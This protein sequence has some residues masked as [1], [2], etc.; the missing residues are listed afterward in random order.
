MR[1]LGIRQ[2]D[3]VAVL[4]NRDEKVVL[5]QLAVLKIG[6]VF[7]PIDSRYP[8]DRIKYILSESGAKSYLSE[9][10]DAIVL[11]DCLFEK[12]A[13]TVNSQGVMAIAPMAPFQN[14]PSD[15]F[16]LYLDRIRDPG[17]LGTIFRSAAACGIKD[18]ILDDCVDIYNPKTIRSSMGMY[19]RCN[20]IPATENVSDGY[21]LVCADADGKD[22]RQATADLRGRPICLVIG[23]EADGV[24]KELLSRADLT[25]SLP[26]C[27]NVESLNAAVS[28]S[29]AMYWFK[30]F[31]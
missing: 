21:M 14:I 4:L 13:D 5:A 6:A 22:I 18:I 30:Y 29:I 17:N 2:G 7:I 26:M 27:K 16:C 20:F 11:T 31:M 1:G 8:E 23:N 24:S 25:V 10:P 28:A 12:I 3:M 19:T 15:D 9:F